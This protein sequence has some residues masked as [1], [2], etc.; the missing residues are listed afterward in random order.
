MNTVTDCKF[1]KDYNTKDGRTGK[2][3]VVTL[4]NNES[5]QAFSEIPVGTPETDLQIEDNGSYGKKIKLIKKNGF[6]AKGFQRAG[7][8]SFA[9][10]YS[11]DCFVALLT[12]MEKA[13]SSQD[14][15]KVILAMADTF[16][17]W[18]EGKRK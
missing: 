7:N 13:P 16:Y 11:K 2:I 9:L 6:A 4:S 5:G 14:A 17:S 12:K 3:Y 10:A 15:A 8:E 1:L 18:M